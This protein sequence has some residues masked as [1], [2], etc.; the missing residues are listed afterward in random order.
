MHGGSDQLPV[1]LDLKLPEIM[2]QDILQLERHVI[3]P[4]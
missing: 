2:T 1:S 3:E 4:L